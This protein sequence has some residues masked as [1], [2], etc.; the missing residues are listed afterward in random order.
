MLQYTCPYTYVH[1]NW[2]NWIDVRANDWSIDRQDKKSNWLSFSKPKKRK[3][4]L[5]SKKRKTNWGLLRISLPT[6]LDL[7]AIT[8]FLQ[9]L[10]NL[11]CSNPWSNQIQ[12]KNLQLHVLLAPSSTAISKSFWIPVDLVSNYSSDIESHELGESIEQAFQWRFYGGNNWP[13]L[14][15][16]IVV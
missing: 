11:L 8:R 14:A 6:L 16:W 9:V 2:S 5:L 12:L 4:W 10:A 1:T 7:A 13:A 3:V 15:F